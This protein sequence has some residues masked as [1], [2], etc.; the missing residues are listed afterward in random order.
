MKFSLM[1]SDLTAEEVV[2]LLAQVGQQA[3]SAFPGR[4]SAIW[5]NG[6]CAA[7]ADAST[8]SRL[9]A[10]AADASTGSGL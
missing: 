6:L 7:T 4:R 10:A 8:G 3:A 5:S 2:K 1:L 9:C